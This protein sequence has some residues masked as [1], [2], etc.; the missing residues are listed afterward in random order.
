MTAGTR[1]CCVPPAFQIHAASLRRGFARAL[2]GALTA[3]VTP[4][5]LVPAFIPALVEYNQYKRPINKG[6]GPV[7]LCGRR[8]CSIPKGS[9][10]GFR[11]EAPAPRRS[12]AIHFRSMNF[13]KP[14]F[15]RILSVNSGL[16]VLLV[17][18]K[19]PILKGGDDGLSS[20]TGAVHCLSTRA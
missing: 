1:Y 19:Q 7:L 9:W 6:E 20:C 14:G 3:S 11:R 5:N 12:F 18:C 13:I 15:N 8:P 10:V 4:Q 16:H 2:R 17:L